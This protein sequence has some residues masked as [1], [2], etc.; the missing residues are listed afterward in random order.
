MHIPDGFLDFK[1]WSSLSVVSLAAGAL[2]V[3]KTRRKLGEKHI[4]LMGTMA[5]FIFA[6]QMINIPVAGG[7][8]GHFLGAALVS[9][10]LGPYAGFL[11]LSVVLIVQCLVFQDGG[12]TALGANV[13]NMAL[14]GCFGSYCAFHG[15]RK[16]VKNVHVSSFAAGW[17][18][19]ALASVLAAVELAVSGTAPLVVVLPAMAGVHAVIG[20]L[21]GF[22]TA[23]V[24]GFII[25]VRPDLAQ[26]E[27]VSPGKAG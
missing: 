20:I 1:T 4:P 2:S 12:L 3:L 27:G 23:A 7:T 11:I 21:E 14:A 9:I 6:A 22:I 19:V 25:K 17:L 24:I 15:I 8:S 18:S 16:L 10:L 13:F 26:L 5:A